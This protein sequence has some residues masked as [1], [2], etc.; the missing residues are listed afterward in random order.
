MLAPEWLL[1]VFI[2][3]RGAGA[4]RGGTLRT[5]LL[6]LQLW[7]IV[8]GAPWHGGAHLKRALQGSK[9]VAP[10]CLEMS[11]SDQCAFVCDVVGVTYLEPC[12]A[13]L[14]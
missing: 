1:S 4:V 11:D 5:W 14:R 2:T 9:L 6:G 7:H 8:N 10:E 13:L 3:T 12:K